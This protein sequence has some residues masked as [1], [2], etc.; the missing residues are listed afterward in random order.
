MKSVAALAAV[1]AT[2]TVDWGRSLRTVDTA[3]T[4]E[5]DVMPF[6]SRAGEGGNYSGYYR[7]LSELGADYVR[8]APWY[9]YPR[10]TVA[11][12]SPP[13]CGG[14]G[15]SWNTTLLDAVVAD[16]MRAVC[17]P[18]A[19]SGDCGAGRSVVPQIS[20]VPSWMFT[21]GYLPPD[22]M[23]ADPWRFPSGGFRYYVRNASS[24]RD[25]TCR[26]MARYVAR[27][28]SW[29]TRGGVVDECG[30]RRESGLYYNW[31]YLSVLNEPSIEDHIPVDLYIRCFD[32]WT[33][34]VA[35]V[36][37]RIRLMGPEVCCTNVNYALKVLD[38]AS[39]IGGKAPAA[40]SSHAGG[41]GPPWSN[42]FTAPDRW[43]LD[44]AGPLS[45]ERDRLSPDTVLI[46]NEYIGFNNEWCA[47]GDC[48]DWQ[49]AASK[50]AKINRTTL[51][52]NAAAA[53]FA[54]GYGRLA[55]LGF[56]IVGMDQLAGG[57]YPDN[58]PAVT[59]LDWD[60]GEPNAK[61]HVARLLAA[62]GS[63]A[64]VL[65]NSTVAGG[66]ALFALPVRRNGTRL[67]LLVSKSEHQQLVE[68]T[69]AAGS[70]GHVVHGVG[71]EPGFSGPR[72]I[73]VSADG[74]VTLGPFAVAL[75]RFP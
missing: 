62:L 18:G 28:V 41:T 20:T 2:V 12:L 11:E 30:V 66:D 8:L 19:A 31:E 21:G 14:A 50:G 25:P 51:G 34:E 61:Y 43:F 57:P 4:V 10:I 37:P 38:P 7:A 47:G 35:A 5:V 1:N 26:E 44:Y 64:K 46:V 72:S 29:Y 58:E 69:A 33:E 49:H 9:P 74:T 6:L 36:N 17:G 13:D 55:L 48:P 16:M 3:A 32:A 73:S 75:L 65:Y 40:I 56:K 60:T 39:H 71:E 27:V 22:D 59:M 52:W 24:L 63:D 42:L 15:S 45:A 53:A 70:T 67:L 68:V 54:Y 23:P